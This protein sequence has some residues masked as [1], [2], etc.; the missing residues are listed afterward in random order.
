MDKIQALDFCYDKNSLNLLQ[1]YKIVSR[2]LLQ[3]TK[4]TEQQ[5]N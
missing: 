1:V 5:K 4:I 3:S 2:L